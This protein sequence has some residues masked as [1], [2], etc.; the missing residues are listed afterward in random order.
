[1]RTSDRADE[2]ASLSQPH[3]RF[4][5][6]FAANLTAS[7]GS[8]HPAHAGNVWDPSRQLDLP[9]L[10]TTTA[11]AAA[12]AAAPRGHYIHQ[13]SVSSEL[14][15]SES[16]GLSFSSVSSGLSRSTQ[17]SP[18][19]PASSAGHPPLTAKTSNV[20]QPPMS[21]LQFPSPDPSA[22]SPGSPSN[23][24]SHSG[25]GDSDFTSQETAYNSRR[26]DRDLPPLPPGT[27][28]DDP[29]S[30]PY[31]LRRPHHSSNAPP[32]HRTGSG[33]VAGS[34][35]GS[36]Y[37]QQHD[38]FGQVQADDYPS[39]SAGPSRPRSGR[40]RMN[41]V[42]AAAVTQGLKKLRK[43]SASAWKNVQQKRSDGSGPFDSPDLQSP[44]SHQWSPHQGS[45]HQDSIKDGNSSDSKKRVLGNLRNASRSTSAL[46]RR[47]GG[48]EDSQPSWDSARLQIPAS[49]APSCR[50][51][52]SLGAGTTPGYGFPP[53]ALAEPD[54][55]IGLP[56]GVQHNVHVDV[57]PE[58]YRGLPASWARHLAEQLDGADEDDPRLRLES[59]ADVRQSNES[60][61]TYRDR[62]GG[63]RGDH[64]NSWMR[65][66]ENH[67]HDHGKEGRVTAS[68]DRFLGD[69]HRD[70]DW[71]FIDTSRAH[72]SSVSTQD[73]SSG[74]RTARPSMAAS[75][76]STSYSS[77][78]NRGW[79]DWSDGQQTPPPPV[80]PLPLHAQSGRRSSNVSPLTSTSPYAAA[81]SVD[82]GKVGPKQPLTSSFDPDKLGLGLNLGFDRVSIKAGSE[83]SPV[84]P[85]LDRQEDEDWAR[86]LMNSLPGGSDDTKI[87]QPATVPRK[88]GRQI[89]SASQR[90]R[91]KSQ[92]AR[93]V[94]ASYS[95]R[96]SQGSS[97]DQLSP[98][99]S[100]ASRKAS[101]RSPQPPPVPQLSADSTLSASVNSR[102]S[103][104]ASK[105]GRKSRAP[106][107]SASR[108]TVRSIKTS[109]AEW[110]ESDE[111]DE[112]EDYT[113]EEESD[114][115]QISTA[116]AEKVGKGT[117]P[118]AL[119]HSQFVDT[120]RS[121]ASVSD[122]GSFASP[123]FQ[124]P[125]HTPKSESIR[126]ALAT[127]VPNARTSPSET[128]S[129][130]PQVPQLF[131]DPRL[132]EQAYHKK[133]GN[134]VVA[135]LAPDAS[136]LGEASQPKS[137]W[138]VGST[139]PTMDPVGLQQ[140]STPGG[141][142]GRGLASLKMGA[143][144]SNAK[145]VAAAAVSASPVGPNS[146]LFSLKTSAASKSTPT[147][148]KRRDSTPKTER[149]LPTGLDPSR[150]TGN[151]DSRG[152]F[153]AASSSSPDPGHNND[154]S[155]PAS[156][157]LGLR[158]RR[159]MN[160]PARIYPP[161][162]SQTSKIRSH[163]LHGNLPDSDS[164]HVGSSDAGSVANA[165]VAGRT[166]STSSIAGAVL[167]SKGSN[168]SLAGHL[169]KG[170]IRDLFRRESQE[171]EHSAARPSE[172]SIG[173]SS[174]SH[175]QHDS[176]SGLR[177]QSRDRSGS[178]ASHDTSDVAPRVPPKD[179]FSQSRPTPS[180]MRGPTIGFIRPDANGFF[181]VSS[182][183][184]SPSR[185]SVDG[186]TGETPSAT[187]V[188][189]TSTSGHQRRAGSERGE[190]ARYTA[191]DYVQRWMHEYSPAVSPA[192]RS[193]GSPSA[194]S[195]LS[196]SHGARRPGVS[197]NLSSPA[198]TRMGHLELPS[199][200]TQDPSLLSP[201]GPSFPSPAGSHAGDSAASSPVSYLQK[202]LPVP[203]DFAATRE[204]T[205]TLHGRSSPSFQIQLQDDQETSVG[206]RIRS[207]PGLEYLGYS[208][209]AV[210]DH[211]ATSS[212]LLSP[213]AYAR[214]PYDSDD[215]NA[216]VRSSIAS[217]PDPDVLEQAAN[218]ANHALAPDHEA[219]EAA[220]AARPSSRLSTASKPSRRGTRTPRRSTDARSRFPVSMHYAS[221][222]SD[223]FF[224]MPDSAEL[225]RE[226]FDLDEV[227]PLDLNDVPPVPPLPAP[228]QYSVPPSPSH[229]TR[230]LPSKPGAQGIA[231]K[232]PKIATPGSASPGHSR[233]PSRSSMGRKS[234]RRRSRSR[235]RAHLP[236]GTTSSR[237]FELNLPEAVKPAARFL[238]S[239]DP[240]A[241]FADMGLIGSGDS[242]D[243]FSAI[244]PGGAASGSTSASMVNAPAPE[245][246]AIKVIKIHPPRD[247]KTEQERGVSRLDA[248]SS[249]LA[250]WTACQHNH[251]LALYDVFY[252]SHTSA[253]PGVWISQEL[254]DR[255][256]ADIVGLK[257]AGLVIE[258]RHMAKLLSDIL[259]GLAALHDRMIIHRDVRSD[260][261]LICSNGEAKLSDFTHAVQLEAQGPE[262]KR[263]SVVGTAYWMAP[264][265]IKAQS[266]DVAVDIWSVGA[267]LYELC[268]GDPPNMNLPPTRA[269]QQIA[270]FGLPPLSKADQY[271]PA[272]R[273]FMKWTT[274]MRPKDRKTAKDLLSTDFI[275]GC[276][277]NGQ[278]VE[279]MD[280]ARDVE[281]T[282]E[283]EE[284]DE[285]EEIVRE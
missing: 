144:A 88:L 147:L 136:S 75:R 249:E 284:E 42:G 109:G 164:G 22:T 49:V 8:H 126:D 83:K 250:L 155:M 116:K 246:V 205:G 235:S 142:L 5:S 103:S 21:L 16:T 24:S 240:E 214:S 18:L 94:D 9:H 264:E 211:I 85:N 193:P 38:T 81:R 203:R 62:D 91:S 29:T 256:L 64:R 166:E 43:A 162:A 194:H 275:V 122:G 112:D 95:S 150:V 92:E 123:K 241:V 141:T 167:Q 63:T 137:A 125:V 198:A 7:Q 39:T 195:E 6:S 243:V 268:E 227:M 252:A 41:S 173:E 169:R 107:R 196:T 181:S 226:S 69:S 277:S 111:Q 269:I 89:S 229:G 234:P 93:S 28:V 40:D 210:K 191:G 182:T 66:A 251:I 151:T 272:L 154:S 45:P 10:T 124:S 2:F 129:R 157:I 1:M 33:S 145:K 127:P 282:L 236:S 117:T 186:S 70:E 274:E 266:Y 283:E 159:K 180:T 118:R 14:S 11:T 25:A 161:N 130:K 61:D 192:A 197:S 276:C 27:P 244:G 190:E 220:N 119:T 23:F 80:P 13:S 188:P 187:H 56:Y 238:S 215:P 114:E 121:P 35:M 52:S 60:P 30:S 178:I 219:I 259:E 221:G 183:G 208:A 201:S 179:A 223:T 177:H 222:F 115:A 101:K 206:S 82:D 172:G 273:E 209:E 20:I 138:S 68:P 271:S 54:P 267:T 168:T 44:A 253:Y 46:S 202:A 50:S 72:L 185:G 36:P 67:A 184:R 37:V 19:S 128:Q 176:G 34:E 105:K 131:I 55:R 96:A 102:P 218:Q 232:S 148:S 207:V 171:P 165:S 224:D 260:N 79:D 213:D 189:S 139:S 76:A 281:E 97:R 258:E 204:E 153:G 106:S 261:V 228:N 156:H 239:A 58:G 78:L 247:P 57:G 59:R 146:P 257:T 87:D 134:A 217:M 152:G 225:P 77:I 133:Y 163:V 71:N 265:L 245:V 74:K 230:A 90:T 140:P 120:M 53:T 143:L 199:P 4:H 255:S 65:A 285:D 170:S 262:S 113:G 98:K 149:P 279:L 12:A 270:Q 278:I 73:D 231:G 242:G 200:S 86:I 108:R 263:K 174:A 280:Q 100:I 3:L 47:K 212:G 104:R 99:A 237:K 110:S 51:A 160:A 48:G 132:A 84:L 26:V 31:S 158:E 254:A 216:P 135:A 32:F 175:Y 15:P 248:L 233:A 17:N